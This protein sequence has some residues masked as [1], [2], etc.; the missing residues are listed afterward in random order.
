M[1]P[2]TARI[3]RGSLAGLAGILLL[4]TVAISCGGSDDRPADHGLVLRSYQV[5]DQTAPEME[6]ILNNILR[7]EEVSYGRAHEGPGGRL[8]VAAPESVQQGV[9]ELIGQLSES[10]PAAPPMITLTC[11]AVVGDPATETE[12]APGLDEIKS[13]LEAIASAEGA[14]SFTLLEKVRLH[15][16]SGQWGKAEG[17]Q[18]ATSQRATAHNDRVIAELEIRTQYR[19]GRI[20][21]TVN[22]APDQLLVL[23]QTRL[24]RRAG[25]NMVI[26][27]DLYLIVRAQVQ[28]GS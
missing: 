24:P 12:L 9:E 1:K 25:E 20:E 19:S 16:L 18:I 21:T 27:R 11:W 23:G 15:S 7:L 6:K 17:Q 10:S 28:T 26:A 8:F 2:I 3:S 22:L 5:P 13:A 14:R 4:V